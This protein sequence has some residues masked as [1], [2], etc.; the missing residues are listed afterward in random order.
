MHEVEFLESFVRTHHNRAALRRMP[1]LRPLEVVIDNWPNSRVESRRVPNNPEDSSAGTREVPFS[2]G[3]GS[4]A[5]TSCSNRPAS[6]T[7]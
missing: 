7:G 4:S 1:V 5:T 2:E 3:C 6:S